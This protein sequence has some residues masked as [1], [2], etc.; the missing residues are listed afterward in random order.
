LLQFIGIGETLEPHIIDLDNTSLD[1]MLLLT[2]DGAHYL[3]DPALIELSKAG[4]AVDKLPAAAIEISRM[5]GSDDNASTLLVPRKLLFSESRLS[6]NFIRV[7]V[8]GNALTITTS[9][10]NPRINQDAEHVYEP[11]VVENINPASSE[12]KK[13]AIRRI[14]RSSKEKSNNEL[15]TRNQNSEIEISSLGFVD[16]E[17][18]S[19]WKDEKN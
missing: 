2:S 8:P 17:T 5:C 9:N 16:D 13:S 18:L 6:L 1:T 7:S 10:A 3:G 19:K 15:K 12:L 14:K 4:L 11:K